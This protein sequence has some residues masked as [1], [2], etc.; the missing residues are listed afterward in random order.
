[1][2]G[3]RIQH[4]LPIGVQPSA[5]GFTAARGDGGGLAGF[6]I[7]GVDLVERIGGQPFALEYHLRSVAVEIA[8][9]RSLAL[10]S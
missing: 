6:K 2:F 7:E 4:T 9:T 1:M 10:E 3:R 5:G 8:F